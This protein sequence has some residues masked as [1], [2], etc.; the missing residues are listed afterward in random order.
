MAAVAPLLGAQGTPGFYVETRTTTVSKGGSGNATTRTHVTRTWTSATC[1]RTEGE[2]FLGDSTSYLLVLGRPPRAL[3]VLPRD[4]VVHATD[5]ASARRRREDAE[6]ILG[7]HPAASLPKLLGDGGVILGH[8]TQKFELRQST[9]MTAGRGV[10]ARAPMVTTYWVAM[11]STDP[12][13]AAHR[14]T[15]PTVTPGA[16]IGTGAGLVLRS[17]SRTQ[18]LRDVTQVTTREVLV[19]RKE[20]V[21]ASRCAIPAGFRTVD[22][23]AEL[24]ARQAAAAELKRLSQ[25]ADPA[26]R[27][28]ARAL[29]D[30][31]LREIKRTSPPP[32]SL[33]DDPRAVLIDGA[34]RKKP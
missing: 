22:R 1:S 21:P 25:S 14:A 26:D 31:L 11:D 4:R 6:R 17:V 20:I 32:A 23:I 24:R 19:W 27:T 29:G 2:A 28:R 13:V 8:R 16:P 7:P 34:G 5:T 33:R 15:R 3:Q 30:S 10:A 18:W 9:E 12:L